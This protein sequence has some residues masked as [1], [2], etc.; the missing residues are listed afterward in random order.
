MILMLLIMAPPCKGF[1]PWSFLNEV[2]HPGAV[3]RA[4]QDGVPLARLC[5]E[6]AASQLA[7][8]QTL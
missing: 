5:A 4:R 3:E 1:G 8:R 6:V 2:I 7:P